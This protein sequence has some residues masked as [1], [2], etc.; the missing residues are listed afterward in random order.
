MNE[1]PL[2]LDT[3][4]E[5]RT[6]ELMEKANQVVRSISLPRGIR[7]TGKV[8]A[9]QHIRVRAGK[10]N[11]GSSINLRTI[12]E[13]AIRRGMDTQIYKLGKDQVFHHS[14]TIQGLSGRQWKKYKRYRKQM[15]DPIT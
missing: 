1:Q 14:H 5:A 4:R 3:D 13:K 10:W 15:G 11:L 6:L 12:T 8:P 9:T 2:I 7:F